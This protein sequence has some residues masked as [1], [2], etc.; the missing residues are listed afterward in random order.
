M[1]NDVVD[2]AD[3]ESHLEKL[4]ERFL[5]R[6][7]TNKELAAIARSRT[8]AAT[9]WTLWAAKEAAY[10]ALWAEGRAIGFAPRRLAVVFASH[11]V[12]AAIETEAGRLSLSLVSGAGWVHVMAVRAGAPRPWSAVAVLE[13]GRNPSQAVRE[14]ARLELGR[15]L[16]LLPDRIGLCGRRPPY[17]VV[18]GR[19]L[20]PGLLSLSHHGRYVAVAGFEGP[21]LGE[22]GPTRTPGGR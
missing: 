2:L 10:K 20:G 6:V 7:F 22:F 12:P 18:A 1:G 15:R 13:P 5:A 8:R 19:C 16:G 17:L 3:R 14:L 9:V 21:L 11:Y 4:H